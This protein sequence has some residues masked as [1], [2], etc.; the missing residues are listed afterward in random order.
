MAIAPLTV[1]VEV[2]AAVRRRTGSK[3][4]RTS[5]FLHRLSACSFWELTEARAAAKIAV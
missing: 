3:A 1:L 2:I 4:E 5:R